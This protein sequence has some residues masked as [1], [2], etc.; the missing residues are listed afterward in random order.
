MSENIYLN[1]QVQVYAVIIYAIKHKAETICLE[2]YWIEIKVLIYKDWTAHYIIIS[3]GEEHSCDV[4]Y[5]KISV[6]C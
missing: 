4:N 5:S 3:E 2:N 6:K 1:A